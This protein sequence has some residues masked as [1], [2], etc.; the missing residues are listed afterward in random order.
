MKMR[1]MYREALKH[2]RGLVAVRVKRI[3]NLHNFALVHQYIANLSRTMRMVMVMTLRRRYWLWPWW[4]SSSWWFLWWWLFRLSFLLWCWLLR[5]WLLWWPCSNW[6]NQW[7][8]CYD[9]VHSRLV[10]RGDWSLRWERNCNIS[11]HNQLGQQGFQS[12]KYFKE[13][14]IYLL[15]KWKNSGCPKWAL[16]ITV[17]KS[18]MSWRWQHCW[19]ALKPGLLGRSN[20]IALLQF[21]SSWPHRNHGLDHSECSTG[22]QFGGHDQVFVINL[23]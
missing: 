15:G 9:K 10:K 5:W 16:G 13:K 11:F 21:F 23:K 22:V 20:S 4:W 8:L 6:V 1:L 18:T 2:G 12:E 17:G 14:I 3:S 19:A 7:F